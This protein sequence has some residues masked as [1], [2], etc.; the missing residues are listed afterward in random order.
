MFRVC[1]LNKQIIYIMGNIFI[2]ILLLL[3]WL[4]SYQ[5]LG[6]SDLLRLF[7]IINVICLVLYCIYFAFRFY[8]WDNQGFGAT[9][10]LLYTILIHTAFLFVS[11]L[12]SL[13]WQNNKS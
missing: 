10:F 1:N 9:L 7:F 2:L 5:I 11:S 8:Y 6:K 4:A 12:I 13:L 3:F